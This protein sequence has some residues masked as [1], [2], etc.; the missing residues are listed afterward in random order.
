ME[1]SLKNTGL[2]TGILKGETAQGILAEYSATGMGVMEVHG[3]FGDL[4]E[5]KRFIANPSVHLPKGPCRKSMALIEEAMSLG[6]ER[7][8]VHP[9]H[10]TKDSIWDEMGSAL[11]IENLDPRSPEFRTAEQLEPIL[12]TLPN[13]MVCLDVAHAAQ[14][15]EI[16]EG[17]IQAFHSKIKQVHLSEIDYRTGKHQPKASP[18]A[19][20]N[21]VNWLKYLPHDIPVVVELAMVTWEDAAQ[22][23][24]RV[25]RARAELRNGR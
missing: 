18:S 1:L 24:Y 4:S 5:I 9:D 21:A 8:I 2:P 7:I 14:E 12:Q 13:A 20:V 22:E 11:L 23:V 16:I 15:P 17:L 6:F 3:D 19:F 10:L 25:A